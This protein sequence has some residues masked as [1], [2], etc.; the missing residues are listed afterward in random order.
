MQPDAVGIPGESAA[1]WTLRKAVAFAGASNEDVLVLGESGSGKTAVSRAVHFSSSRKSGPIAK[2][3]AK[4]FTEN[5]LESQLFG[6]KVGII[7]TGKQSFDGLFPRANGCTIV[8]D[9]IG[10]APFWLQEAL[11]SVLDDGELTVVDAAR[12]TTVDVIIVGTANQDPM[13][14]FRPDFAARLAICVIGRCFG[15]CAVQEAPYG[16]FDSLPQHQPRRSYIGRSV[17][18]LR[19][20]SS[21]GGRVSAPAP[22]SP[23][24]TMNTP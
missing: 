21:Q 14:A 4:H 8:L 13:Q 12:G 17:T 5:M 16:W 24:R 15:T 7:G 19:G 20:C 11:R 6:T 9:E 3:S 10:L 1:S 18:C 23:Q 2:R 22:E